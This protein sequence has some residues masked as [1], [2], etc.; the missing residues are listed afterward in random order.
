MADKKRSGAIRVLVYGTLKQGQSNQIVMDEAGGKFMGYDSTTGPHRIVDLGG[1]P[2]VVD[3]PSTLQ[4]V[5]G[6]LYKVESEGLAV[7][8]MLEGH[9][10]F[11]CRQKLWTDVMKK[12]A[13]I[14]FM[15]NENWMG[16]VDRTPTIKDGLWNPT[17][18]EATYWKLANVG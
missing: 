11:Y 16:R 18:Q 1:L 10:N 12:K 9:P 13:W 14:Y 8:D 15:R 4:T 7:L 17:E 3:A 5:R 6:Q 2:A